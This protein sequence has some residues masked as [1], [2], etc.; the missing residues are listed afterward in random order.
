MDV[1]GVLDMVL[2]E[3]DLHVVT[4]ERRAGDGD[5]R[6]AHAEEPS[7]H[8]RPFRFVRVDVEVDVFD[9]ADLVADAVDDGAALPFVD[10][11]KDLVRHVDSSIV[12]VG[13][14]A[15]CLPI[16]SPNSRA[17]AHAS[18]VVC[19]SWTRRVALERTR[20]VCGRC[21]CEERAGPD[22]SS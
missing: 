1:R 9:L 22:R 10:P 6:V 11:C 4:G 20:T 15:R 5:D 3:W 12:I 16:A 13:A 17:G 21:G 19:G 2:V 14:E 7:S 18:K 8:A